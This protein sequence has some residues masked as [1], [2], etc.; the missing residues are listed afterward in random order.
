MSH[1]TIKLLC[2]NLWQGG[3]FFEKIFDFLDEVNPD[4]L[5]LQ[6]VYNEKDIQLPK[7][8]RSIDVLQKHGNYPYA[9]FSPA[10][11]W[12]VEGRIL[13]QGNAVLTRIPQKEQHTYF[14]DIPYHPNYV[15]KIG[16]YE[17]KDKCY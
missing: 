11:K 6:E 15:E 1:Y 5:A 7:R 9:Y 12:N 4:I 10:L 16:K 13:E 8:L 3:K 17:F 14:Y 2:L